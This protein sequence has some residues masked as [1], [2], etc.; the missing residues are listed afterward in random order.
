MVKLK[1]YHAVLYILSSIIIL[2]TINTYAVDQSSSSD[3]DESTTE[4]DSAR[5]GSGVVDS[6]GIT[7]STGDFGRVRGYVATSGGIIS[8]TLFN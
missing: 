7:F 5:D 6:A 2:L 3:F 4:I 8:T 1:H